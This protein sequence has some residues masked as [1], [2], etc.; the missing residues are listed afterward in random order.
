MSTTQLTFL[1]AGLALASALFANHVN[2]TCYSSDLENQRRCPIP[3]LLAKPIP[4]EIE[5]KRLREEKARL[6]AEKS[7]MRD[8]MAVLQETISE[9]KQ[10]EHEKTLLRQQVETMQRQLSQSQ[11]T[12]AE[13]AVLRQQVARLEQKLS[14]MHV[15]PPPLPKPPSVKTSVSLPLTK[16]GKVDFEMIFSPP[17]P[18][19]DEFE[20]KEE[21]VTRLREFEQYQVQLVETLN[22]AAAQHD[23]R[24]QAGTAQLEKKNYNVDKAEFVVQLTWA[25]WVGQRFV[26]DEVARISVGRDMAKGLFEEGQQKPIFVTLQ[27]NGHQKTVASSFLA[28]LGKEINLLMTPPKVAESFRDKLKDGSLGPELVQIP[29]GTFQMGSN[30]GSSDEKPVH[31]VTVKSFAMGKYEVTFEEYDKFCEATRRSKPDDEGWG[32]GKR[33]VINVTWNDAKA[34]VNWLSEQ[35]GKNYQLPS[36]AQWEYA[37]RAGTTTKY[38]WGNEIGKNNANCRSCGSQWDDKQTAPVGSFKPNPFGLYDISGNVWEW[39]ED[40][41]HDSYNGAPVDGSAWMSGG[42]SS[43]HL[44]RGGSWIDDGDSVRCANRNWVDASYGYYDRG[45]RISRM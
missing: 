43:N 14:E 20:T 4:S 26:L 13:R 23:L 2:N 32:R 16:N 37:C 3:F 41:W 30:D 21:F 5:I 11:Q 39:L 12:E 9:L 36:E 25:D 34:Y 7:T 31:T 10:G 1:A 28:G 15:S 6:D 19:R 38:W 8:Q 33:P 40:K 18:V 42:D 45:F 27:I 24:V 22:Q 17:P 29:A 35:T 44:L